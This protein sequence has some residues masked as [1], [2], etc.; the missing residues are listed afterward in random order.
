MIDG[1]RLKITS[2]LGESGHEKNRSNAPAFIEIYIS[3]AAW[4][5]LPV[6]NIQT[7][8]HVVVLKFQATT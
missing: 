4:L 8:D 2:R 6:F 5:V 3:L 7:T 1:G